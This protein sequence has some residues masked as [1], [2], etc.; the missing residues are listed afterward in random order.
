[1]SE[2]YFIFLFFLRRIHSSAGLK[3]GNDGKGEWGRIQ[4]GLKNKKVFDFLMFDVNFVVRVYFIAWLF[5]I[6]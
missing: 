5:C 3:W 6:A 1:M 2:E 4:T